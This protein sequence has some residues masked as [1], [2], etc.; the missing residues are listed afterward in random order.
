MPK[1]NYDGNARSLLSSLSDTAAVENSNVLIM[2]RH[3]RVRRPNK[4]LIAV[5]RLWHYFVVYSNSHMF[6]HVASGWAEIPT[7]GAFQRLCTGGRRG[8]REGGQRCAGAWLHATVNCRP[9]VFLLGGVI[10]S[11][12]Y[13]AAINSHT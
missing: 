12:T 6:T 3:P 10:E 4:W 9:P 7:V 13:S 5:T 2:H 1:N 8:R 11:V